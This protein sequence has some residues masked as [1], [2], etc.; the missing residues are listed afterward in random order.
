MRSIILTDNQHASLKVFIDHALAK[1]YYYMNEKLYREI[2]DV[3]TCK[4]CSCGNMDD[5][6]CEDTGIPIPCDPGFEEG[7]NLFPLFCWKRK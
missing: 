4:T 7:P 6:M 3:K 1:D 2:M 5:L